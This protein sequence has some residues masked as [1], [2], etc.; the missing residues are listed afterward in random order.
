[1]GVFRHLLPKSVSTMKLFLTTLTILATQAMAN[2]SYEGYQVL[3]TS[4]LTKEAS[5]VLRE[6][7]LNT[8]S[9][10][11]WRDPIT[12]RSTDIN[13]PPELLSNIKD[14]LASHGVE[15]STMIEDVEKLIKET[16]PAAKSVKSDGKRYAMNWDD[17]QR[18]DVLNEFIESLADANDFASIIPIGQSYEGRDMKV[19]AITKAGPGAPSIWLEAGI[20]AREWIAPAVGTYLIRELVEEYEDHPDYLD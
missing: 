16:E 3:R 14:M 17:Y 5:A 19:L 13:T 15:V 1:M 12:G 6:L 4:P 8:N 20:H 18:H 7:Q 2:T 10:D 11:F 9:L